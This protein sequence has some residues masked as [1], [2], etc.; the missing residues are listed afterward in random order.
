MIYFRNFILTAAH[1]GCESSSPSDYKVTAGEHDR[2]HQSGNERT[3]SIQQIFKHPSYNN[4]NFD[5][6]FCLLQTTE[7][8][9]FNANIQ[10]AC[11]SQSCTDECPENAE[12]LVSG[13][14]DTRVG[15]TSQPNFL[16]K[17]RMPIV[18]RTTCNTIYT[19]INAIT[20]QMT[21]AGYAGS[22]GI[23]TCQGDAGGAMVCYRYGYFQ[24]DGIASWAAG[25]EYEDKP[26]VFSRVCQV[27][28]WIESTLD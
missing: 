11:L 1:C 24:V 4:V 7:S 10:P 26:S 28:D 8:I 19:G 9:V 20:D 6:D 16:K 5:Y 23:S 22:G 14:G 12:I 13:W 18:P 17:A 3:Y 21:C 2:Q 25:C 27:L 15:A